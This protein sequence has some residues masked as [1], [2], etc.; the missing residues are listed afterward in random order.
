MEG[1]DRRGVKGREV[2]KGGMEG[3]ERDE[4]RGRREHEEKKGLV[5]LW[6]SH[7]LTTLQW[8]STHS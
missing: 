2:G 3:N 4:R 1:V 8:M 5:I 6:E 7:M